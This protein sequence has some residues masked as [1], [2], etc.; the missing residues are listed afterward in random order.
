MDTV[1]QR[2]WSMIAICVLVG[3]SKYLK[4]Y[5]NCQKYMMPINSQQCFHELRAFILSHLS[6]EKQRF[7]IEMYYY[8]QS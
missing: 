3:P 1:I 5:G 6:D 4:Y 2:V 7:E 8:Q